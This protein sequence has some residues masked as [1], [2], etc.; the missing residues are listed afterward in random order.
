MGTRN[1]G[2]AALNLRRWPGRR[3]APRGLP[4]PPRGQPR[5]AGLLR[6]STN[7]CREAGRS[8]VPRA[9]SPSTNMPVSVSRRRSFSERPAAGEPAWSSVVSAL[10]SSVSSS[11]ICT[12]GCSG[13][14][15]ST[16]QVM[17][18]AAS[19]IASLAAA[20]LISPRSSSGLAGLGGSPQHPRL[21]LV[22]ELIAAP[23][24]SSHLGG[25]RSVVEQ[26]RRV[27]HADGG[28]GEVLHLDQDVHRAVQLGE[29]RLVVFWRQRHRWRA[30]ELPELVHALFGAADHAGRRRRSRRRRVRGRT[31]SR[32]PCGS[33]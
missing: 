10:V 14:P 33:P 27:R 17:S 13:S 32:C 25:Q 5:S 4:R 11:A 7:R 8:S 28:L 1:V 20:R 18:L 3:S 30:G 16:Y 12:T 21:Q 9:G 23:L 6:A 22:V 19:H 26:E 29:D 24:E 31:A 2:V 15:C